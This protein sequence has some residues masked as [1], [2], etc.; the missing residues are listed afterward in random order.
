[1]RGRIPVSAFLVLGVFAVS[2]AAV[3]D[4]KK[5]EKYTEKVTLKV[6]V[7]KQKIFLN[8]MDGIDAYRSKDKDGNERFHL[9]GKGVL[10]GTGKPSVGSEIT[11]KDGAVY[12]VT[13][14]VLSDSAGKG[15]PHLCQVTLKTPAKKD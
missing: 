11:D 5:D 13:K 1:M 9:G 4:E 3:S 12:T 2:A 10:V 15:V 7:E 6:W 14:V 8:P